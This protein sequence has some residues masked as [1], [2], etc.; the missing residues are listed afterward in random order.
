MTYQSFKL[1]LKLREKFV[2]VLVWLISIVSCAVLF[3]INWLLHYVSAYQHI[4]SIQVAKASLKTSPENHVFLK[5]FFF[6]FQLKLLW[7][8]K[9]FALINN[10]SGF[11]KNIRVEKKRRCLLNFKA[12][13]I[14]GNPSSN[15]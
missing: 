9:V 4:A 8:E 11:H 1:I 12:K 13:V 3:V 7:H 15:C 6:H 14:L 10:Y 2:I 5:P